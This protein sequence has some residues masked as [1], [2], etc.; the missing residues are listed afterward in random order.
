MRTIDYWCWLV[1]YIILL[2][3]LPIQIHTQ[4]ECSTLCHIDQLTHDVLCINNFSPANCIYSLID[5]SSLPRFQ[6]E[7][8]L[9]NSLLLLSFSISHVHHP[10]RN[11]HSNLQVKS[12]TSL[13]SDHELQC[14]ESRR[15]INIFKIKLQIQQSL[16]PTTSTQTQRL[17][18]AM[19]ILK[20]RCKTIKLS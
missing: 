15:E 5:I 19:S 11:R 14:F 20:P 3:W 7:V 4:M 8:T 1:I 18:I 16:N 17:T 13:C 2:H 9:A 6:K 12:W 10:W